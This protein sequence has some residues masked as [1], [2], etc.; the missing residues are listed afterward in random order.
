MRISF[1]L[2]SGLLASADAFQVH[3]AIPSSSRALSSGPLSAYIDIAEQAPR[4]I[5]AMDQWATMCQVQRAEG[6]QLTT[7]DGMDFSAMTTTEI[8]E[9]SPILCVPGNMILSTSSVKTEMGPQA[10]S[11]DYLSRYGSGDQV[12]KF[13]LFLKIIAEYEQGDQSPYFPW[14]NSLPRTYYN[15][16][17]MTG[18]EN[19]DYK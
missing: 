19:F 3:Q 6:F 4:D 2:F 16:I 10:A 17:S 1:L 11:V 9:G 5:G 12:G 7:E 15:A 8:P 13:F 18:K 14:L